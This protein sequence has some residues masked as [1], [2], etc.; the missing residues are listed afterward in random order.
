[1]MKRLLNLML[2]L[3]LGCTGLGILAISPGMTVNAA[4]ET[5]AVKAADPTETI[6]QGTFGTCRYTV[7][8]DGRMT[9]APE[10]GQSGTLGKSNKNP[11]NN[12]NQGQWTF[13]D[14]VAKVTS[15]YIAPGV[16]GNYN[17]SNLFR[18]FSN[19]KSI[20]LSNFDATFVIYMSSMFE[21]CS[22]LT[23]IKLSSTFKNDLKTDTS[24]LFKNCES[25]KSLDLSSLDTSKVTDMREMFR[26]CASLTELNLAHFNTEKVTDM[27]SM[28]SNCKNLQ[29]INLDSFNTKG[30]S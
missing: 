3:L 6:A 7:D 21:D 16:A 11:W 24:A 30:S 13:P 15:I 9:I 18:G 8:Q 4:S 12:F 5:P 27:T 29:E 28:F 23:E 25:L 26:G 19:V 20:D 1:M 14:W 10:E 17:S 2:F 22:K